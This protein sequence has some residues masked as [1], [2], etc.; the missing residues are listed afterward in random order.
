MTFHFEEQ[1]DV[2]AP[3]ASAWRFLG[4]PPEML[5]CVPGAELTEQ[6]GPERWAG[7]L[8]MRAGP[9]RLRYQGTLLV[10]HREDYAY[11][12][13]L[14]ADVQ[15]TSD[16]AAA[17]M[18]VSIALETPPPPREHITTARLT[19]DLDIAG[20]IAQLGPGMVED[21]V[22]QLIREFIDCAVAT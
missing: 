1:F 3:A 8:T 7:Q 20:R 9:A 21:V 22:R 19:V 18:L 12:A 17:Q 10:E 11:R 2:R 13:R 5:R 14:R 16:G 4:E 6:T 15:D